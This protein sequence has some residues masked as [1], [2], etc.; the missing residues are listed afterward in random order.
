MVRQGAIDNPPK[1]PFTLGFECSGE[2]EVLGENV[3]RFQVK[4]DI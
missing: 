4:D 2:V 3:E 1:T